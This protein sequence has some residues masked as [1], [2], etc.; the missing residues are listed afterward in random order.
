MLHFDRGLL[1][2]RYYLLYD[3]MSLLS[4]VEASQLGDSLDPG[5][6]TSTLVVRS[7]LLNAAF[8]HVTFACCVYY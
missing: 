3:P 5:S 7:G 6:A 2:R 4:P 1:E 8:T